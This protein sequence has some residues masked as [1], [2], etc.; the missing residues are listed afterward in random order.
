[1]SM[2][3]HKMHT[4]WCLAQPEM[5][6][7]IVASPSDGYDESLRNKGSKIKQSINRHEEEDAV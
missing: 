6:V 4:K 7:E 2:P 1:M 5:P 3:A